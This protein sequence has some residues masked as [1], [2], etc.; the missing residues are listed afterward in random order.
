MRQDNLT[1][2]T[3]LWTVDP[4]RPDPRVMA[5]AGRIIRG[6]GLVA[7]PTE[8]VYGLGA[9]ALDGAAVRRIFAAKGRPADNPLIVHIGAIRDLAGVTAETGPVADKLMRR[10]WPG[11]LTLVLPKHPGIPAG[12]TAGLDTVGVRMPAH[13]VA[14][15]LVRA[16]GVPIAAP[17]ANASGRPS[18]T[19]AEHVWADLAGRVE[20]ILD[21]GP[22]TV[23]LESTVLDLS[24]PRPVVLRPGGV[25]VEA[26]E[27]VL[28]TEIPVSGEGGEIPRSP[29]MKYTH[30]AP[31]AT[32]L[33]IDGPSGAVRREIG[34]RARDLRRAGR[35]V[36]VLARKESAGDYAGLDTI[37][38]GSR[39]DPATVAAGLYAALR[40][41]DA[42]GADVILAEGVESRGVGRAVMNRLRKAAK[43]V[44][45]VKHPV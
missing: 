32:L 16:A 34:R 38:C 42:A 43:E 4:A 21:G 40:D 22:A 14:L 23:G 2:K 8:T 33:L 6:G 3:A 24:G 11:P 36:A 29:G 25:T 13:P 27:A 12:V 28:Q 17:S 19:R 9:N 26:L 39:G 31:R 5:R 41:C 7:F 35:R 30:Y 15:H 1:I 18:P 20:V 10:F 37:L 45:E 44:I